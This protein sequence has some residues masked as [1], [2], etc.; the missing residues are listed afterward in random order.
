[1]RKDEDVSELEARIY[2]R[3]RWYS[4]RFVLLIFSNFDESSSQAVYTE[5]SVDLKGQGNIGACEKLRVN[6]REQTHARTKDERSL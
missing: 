6:V 2:G 4:I 1:M 5:I 3:K